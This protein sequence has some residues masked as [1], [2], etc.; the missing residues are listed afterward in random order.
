MFL[1]QE[2]YETQVGRSAASDYRSMWAGNFRR[3]AVQE[4]GPQMFFVLQKA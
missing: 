2:F 4:T 3:I 1:E